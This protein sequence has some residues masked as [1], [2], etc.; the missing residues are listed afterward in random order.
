MCE[1]IFEKLTQ[2][3]HFRPKF[4]YFLIKNTEIS[5][6]T[7]VLLPSL[8]QH[9]IGPGPVAKGPVSGPDRDS[10]SGSGDQT[11]GPVD[12]YLGRAGTSKQPYDFIPQG[13]YFDTFLARTVYP[14]VSMSILY[15]NLQFWSHWEP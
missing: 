7:S 14:D 15:K 12:H 9:L 3:W 2:K 13:L 5:K 10:W 8:Y 1:T 4:G 11:G 6:K